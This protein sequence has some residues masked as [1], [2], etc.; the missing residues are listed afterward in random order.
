MSRHAERAL[1]VLAL[2]ATTAN[3]LIASII[4]A[5]SGTRKGSAPECHPTVTTPRPPLE[6]CKEPAR[7][8]PRIQGSAAPASRPGGCDRGG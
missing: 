3:V 7:A 8:A 4:R 2:C 5:A 1:V 6:R